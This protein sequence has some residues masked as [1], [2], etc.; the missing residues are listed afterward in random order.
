MRLTKWKLLLVQ[1]T[2]W[3]FRYNIIIQKGAVGDGKITIV[4]SGAA[5]TKI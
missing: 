2:N 1:T 3:G 4:D 5:W